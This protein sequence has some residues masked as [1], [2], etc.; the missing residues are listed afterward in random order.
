[1]GLPVSAFCQA[2]APPS[3]KERNHI[4]ADVILAKELKRLI[5]RWHAFVKSIDTCL[6]C[7]HA[8]LII[9]V[10]KVRAALRWHRDVLI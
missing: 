1:M 8:V 9:R 6:A 10:Q 7:H 2:P 3:T 4:S 5:C